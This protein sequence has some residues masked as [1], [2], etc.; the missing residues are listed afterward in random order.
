M[1][2]ENDCLDFSERK[3]PGTEGNNAG[4]EGF[5][6]SG[7]RPSRQP[8]RAER[9]QKNFYA[10][11]R[12]GEKE[13]PSEFRIL[14][15]SEYLDKTTAGF[16]G[17]M[18]GFFSG[19]E[20]V[21]R[22]GAPYVA[23]PD[24]WYRLCGGPYAEPNSHKKNEQKLV[25]NGET[26]K[27]EVFMDDDYSIDILNQYILRD[28]YRE[29]G[30][31]T[32]KVITDGW[33]KYDVYDMGGGHRTVGAYGLMKSH[34]YLP[35]F[36]G[37]WE[38][39]NRY[40]Y[41][42]EPAI[43][44]ETLGMVTAG[45]PGAASDLTEIFGRATGDQDAVLWAK[46]FASLYA[47]AYFESDIPTLIKKGRELV[48]DNCVGR[49]VDGVFRLREEFPG[50]WR[51]AAR[52]AERRFARRHDRMVRDIMLEPNVNSAFVL[53][54]LLYGG[55]DYLETCKIV[56]LCGYD[57]DS[58]SAICMGLMGILCGMKDLPEE[59]NEKIWQDGEG[60]LLNREVP[61]LPIG[62]WMCMKNLPERM[63]IKDL[64]ELY[65]ENF[66]HI[67][68]EC[69]GK[70]EGGVYHIPVR[71]TGR[72]ETVWYEDFESGGLAKFAVSGGRAETFSGGFEGEHTAR[73]LSSGGK[74]AF[75]KRKIEGLVAGESY[76]LSCYLSTDPTG[77]A[78]IFLRFPNGEE[79]ISSVRGTPRHILRR[80]VF[81]AKDT[82]AEFGLRIP[83]GMPDGS[84]VTFDYV[85]ICRVSEEETRNRVTILSEEEP[86]GGYKGRLELSVSGSAPHEVLLKL[87]FAYW[88][89]GPLDA[90]LSV[91]GESFNTAAFYPTLT[92]K[93]GLADAVYLP[94]LLEKEQNRVVLTF[95]EQTLFLLSAQVVTLNERKGKGN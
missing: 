78:E 27:T 51:E 37:A 42:Y 25:P 88:G 31:V 30:K 22:D 86:D 95:G 59:V 5:C 34:R 26:G 13:S 40:S 17:Q 44:N 84:F 2:K 4:G 7:D 91:N 67:L 11:G 71:E 14:S 70:V 73:L 33:I 65:R 63:K 66:E 6:A 24:D 50:D 12:G 41:C 38:F 57:G 60:I 29:F 80:V 82:E 72:V 56:S 47:A 93:E 1:K 36:A 46:F 62:Y 48:P 15:V 20:F 3:T 76:R 23:M 32:S 74:E 45:M 87:T 75:A 53:I 77:A 10:L 94:I 92:K 85:T 21:T 64:V 39:G 61:G 90:S 58:T 68:T 9:G 18:V 54:A 43:E 8:L 35:E 79:V 19:Y 89:E 16:L 69:G 49:T 83:A 55:G 81:T 28:M 52:E